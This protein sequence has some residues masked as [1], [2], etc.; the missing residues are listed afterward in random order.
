MNRRAVALAATLAAA[1]CLAGCSVPRERD[2][3]GTTAASGAATPGGAGG[4][5]ATPS[6]SAVASGPGAGAAPAAV[7]S[8]VA[9]AAPSPSAVPSPS[10]APVRT[11]V[12]HQVA[13]YALTAPPR[14][15]GDPLGVVRGARDLFGAAT[16]RSVGKGGAPLGVLMLLALRPEYVGNRD[17]EQ[18]LVPKVVAGMTSG[19]VKPW[20][21][22]WSGLRVAVVMSAK[23]GTIV[24]WYSRGVLGVVVG[25]ADPAVVTG[26]AKAYVASR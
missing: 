11:P 5:V 4:A 25:G 2:Q 18:M 17:I 15:L 7:S 12:P 22:T 26:Y 24:V 8:P 6:V 13:G 16:A 20:F 3:G 19:G 21:A 1:A 9:V 14:S 10:A 23:D